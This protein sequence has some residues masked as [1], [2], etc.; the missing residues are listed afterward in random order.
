MKGYN[1][2]E[3]SISQIEDKLKEITSFISKYSISVWQELDDKKKIKIKTILFE[4]LKV[5]Y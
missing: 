3:Y 1:K 4:V 2:P 5:V